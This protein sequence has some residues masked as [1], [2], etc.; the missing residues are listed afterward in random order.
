MDIEI[1]LILQ[2]FRE[3]TGNIFTSFMTHISTYGESLVPVMIMMAIYWC[4]DKKEGLFILI[5]EGLAALLNGFLKI[6]FCVYRPWIRDSRIEPANNA[7]VTATGYS[8][9]SGHTMTATAVYGGV[10]ANKKATKTLR[11][12]MIFMIILIGFSRLYLGVHT[13]QDVLVGVVSTVILLYITRYI[14]NKV[15]EKPNLDIWVLIIGILLNVA[16][17]I[18]TTFKSYPLDYDS[19]GA[20]IVDPAK[21]M[22]D[23]YMSCGIS[24]GTLV[25]WFVDRKW[26]NYEIKGTISQKASL[27]A[28]GMLGYFFLHYVVS[29]L[30]PTNIF[31]YIFSYFMLFVYCM[32]VVPFFAKKFIK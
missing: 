26:L 14:L 5:S 8:F 23:T 16:V 15:D 28:I 22:R 29:P 6:T 30:M 13:P 3:I 25:S 9:P 20:L 24:L 12:I 31:G 18:F 27:Y 19:T 32:L 7:K 2:N 4:I 17:I 21:M 10:A 11:Y 1:L